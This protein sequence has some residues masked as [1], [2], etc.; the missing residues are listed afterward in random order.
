MAQRILT[1][2]VVSLLFVTP[3][4]GGVESDSPDF[5]DNVYEYLGSLLPSYLLDYLCSIND[6]GDPLSIEFNSDSTETNIREAGAADENGDR[7]EETQQQLLL[8][9]AP[10][11]WDTVPAT[12]KASTPR[13]LGKK[14]AAAH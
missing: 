7:P 2:L 10:W 4:F 5:C 12:S 8:L 9:L 6:L 3:G 11:S 1:A 13:R 14:K